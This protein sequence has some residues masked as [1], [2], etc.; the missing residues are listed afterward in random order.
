[1]STSS[2]LLTP[3]STKLNN[4]TKIYLKV[5]EITNPIKRNT[6]YELINQFNGND[7][8]SFAKPYSAFECAD[9]YKLHINSRTRLPFQPFF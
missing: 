5:I 4:S 9:S 2:Y 8:Q 3:N 6:K 7:Y 1:M